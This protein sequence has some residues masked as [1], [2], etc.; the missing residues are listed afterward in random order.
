[1][2]LTKIHIESFGKLQNFDLLPQEGLN[3]LEYPNGWGKTT[4]ANFLCAMLYGLPGARSATRKN[5]RQQYTP[6]QGGAYGG[7]IELSS[8]LGDFRIER[9]FDPL[10]TTRD[11]LLVIDKSSGRPTT[12]LGEVPGETLLGVN[13]EGFEKSVYLTQKEVEVTPGAISSIAD[14]LH[15]LLDNVEDAGSYDRAVKL[16][17][18]AKRDLRGGGVR[19]QQ[20]EIRYTDL[21]REIERLVKQQAD[22]KA[23]EAERD[24]CQ[25]EL[26]DLE[27]DK[28]SYHKRR[29]LAAHLEERKRLTSEISRNKAEIAELKRIFRAKLPSEEEFKNVDVACKNL[30]SAASYASTLENAFPK[31]EYDRLT[32]RYPAGVPSEGAIEEAEQ[33][34]DARKLA[35]NELD[36]L[37]EEKP[38]KKALNALLPSIL[39]LALGAGLLLPALLGASL[40]FLIGAIPM[41]LCG[42]SW[43]VLS[44]LR[45]NKIKALTEQIASLDRSFAQK[46]PCFENPTADEALCRRLREDTSRMQMLK[47]EKARLDE[48][49]AKKEA[50]SDRLTT[51]FATYGTQEDGGDPSA[52]LA[53]LQEADRKLK[54]ILPRL[55]EKEEALAAFDKAHELTPEAIA[56]LP[57]DED[58]PDDAER[59]R[60]ISL[61]A[62]ELER[63]IGA[64]SAEIDQI[65]ELT[66]QL[67]NMEEELRQRKAKHYL[68][69]KTQ[70]YLQNAKDA[71]SSRYRDGIERSFP[72][73]LN[74][75]FGEDAPE[76]RVDPDM[77]VTLYGGGKSRPVT[78]FSQGMQ[79]LTEFCLRLSLTEALT[80]SEEHPFLLL[81]DPFVNLDDERYSAARELLNELANTYQIFYFVC[82]KERD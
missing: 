14:R 13:V 76:A 32:R 81:D 6:W 68:L 36:A 40:L 74:R 49:L 25:K 43:L 64:M 69:E 18:R 9:S 73:F 45:K 15:K 51:F 22:L 1:M 8:V 19:L 11:E 33:I 12:L 37:T 7:Y 41:L 16:I 75:L 72:S 34:A 50:F 79:D 54:W 2:K 55:S 53:R 23:L 38:F 10:S 24:A 46:L 70:L 47:S 56:S 60:E 57:L 66:D 28:D 31:A 82:R 62:Q 44:L 30:Q 4:L 59:R 29:E 52:T 78:A 67:S 35:K 3:R 21:R 58:L 65:P 27:A 71:L 63:K 5:L 20:L 26:T 39:L 48:A 61:R 42:A 17:D 80:D 77:K